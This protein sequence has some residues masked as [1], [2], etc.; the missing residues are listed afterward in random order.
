MA[1]YHLVYFLSPSGH[2]FTMPLNRIEGFIGAYKKWALQNNLAIIPSIWV[3]VDTALVYGGLPRDMSFDDK[4]TVTIISAS[5]DLERHELA[6]KRLRDRVEIILNPWT[7]WEMS[8]L[9]V[10]YIIS[11][12]C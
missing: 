6:D 7:K 1:S 11:L 9:Y 8:V 4:W 2:L 10:R 12:L 3:V 5:L